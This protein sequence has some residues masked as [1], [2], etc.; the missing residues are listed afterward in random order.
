LGK[1]LK[2]KKEM[3]F[4]WL[5]IFP[6]VCFVFLLLLFWFIPHPSLHLKKS[7]IFIGSAEQRICE[8]FV[9]VEW[10]QTF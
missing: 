8:I 4:E 6:S 1:F 7:F 3:C 10:L 9:L 2:K 5:F